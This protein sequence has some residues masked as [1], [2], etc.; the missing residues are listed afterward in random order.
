[1]SVLRKNCFCTPRSNI[2]MAARALMAAV[3]WSAA[4]VETAVLCNAYPTSSRYRS[5]SACCDSHFGLR[6]AARASASRV[7]TT[8][9]PLTRGPEES[10]AGRSAVTPNTAIR[11]ARNV[12]AMIKRLRMAAS[13]V[14]R[15]AG[16]GRQRDTSEVICS[17]SGS[18]A[19]SRPHISGCGW[20]AIPAGRWPSSCRD[21]RKTAAQ[22]IGRRRPI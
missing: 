19:A 7:W 15:A 9:S 16:V 12:T 8:H 6:M 11:L 10:P 18:G 2:R 4:W 1:M 13:P 21:R 20:S 3:A 22:R 14:E 5:I 17:R